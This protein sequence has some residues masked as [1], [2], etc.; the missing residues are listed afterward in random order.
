[1]VPAFAATTDLP[2]P[3]VVL[4][5]TPQTRMPIHTG[6]F[7]LTT[8]VTDHVLVGRVVG[9]AD[10]KPAAGAQILHNG[11]AIT[12]DEN[13]RFRIEGLVAG[14]LELHASPSD[15]DT[16]AAPVV[17]QIEI[18]ETPT[19]IEHDV[20]LPRGVVVTGRVVDR[21]TGA[22]VEKA[23][24]DFLPKPEPGQSPTI[25]GFSKETGRD[26]RFRFVVPPGR[27]TIT[28]QTFP[29]AYPKSRFVGEPPSPEYSREVLGRAGQTIE[30]ADF[31]LARGREAVLRVVNTDGRPLAN[32]QVDVRDPT[33]LSSTAPGRSDAAG[34]YT[35]VGLS[36]EASMVIDV[37]DAGKSLGATI[38]IPDTAS[39]GGNGKELEI[40]LVPLASLSGRVLDEDGKPLRRAAVQLFRDVNYPGQ[41]RRSFGVLIETQNE[42]KDD[43]T[44]TF[45]HLIAGATY[46]SR[47]EVT[48]HATGTSN[49]V[50][51]KK[52][53]G[54]V[55]FNDFRLP[56]VDQEV[57][58]VVVDPRGKPLTAISVSYERSGR[59]PLYAPNGGV[60]FQDTDEAG[61]FHLTSLPRGPV[62]LMVYRNP[63]VADRQIKG[64][65]YVDVTPGQADIRIVLPDSNDRLRGID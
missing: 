23:L 8:R 38:E 54:P 25:F 45:D 26:G 22:G 31:T 10:G 36:P 28:L 44:Y 60:W 65:K 47:V 34:R 56:A 2:Q 9:E 5:T 41:S 20:T 32:A 14:K 58:G 62:R 17:A 46:N 50:T 51:L 3:D 42:I 30:V 18:P 35:V 19:T 49:H 21:T 63:Q 43:G 39:A 52:S 59:T 1:M 15:S 48:G 33:R 4:P 40:P 64:I 16:G 57:K 55:R 61:R 24:V 12:A 13:G 7:T 6:E 37:I 53:G 11:I 27:G 29:A